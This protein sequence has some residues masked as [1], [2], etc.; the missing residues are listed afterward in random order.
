MLA[1]DWVWLFIIRILTTG[2]TTSD[3]EYCVP[4][5]TGNL[6]FFDYKADYNFCNTQ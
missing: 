3:Y 4:G 6:G 2:I 5:N 1:D